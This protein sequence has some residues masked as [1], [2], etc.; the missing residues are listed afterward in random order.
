MPRL[1]TTRKAIVGLG[2]A[3]GQDA[4]DPPHPLGHVQAH[5]PPR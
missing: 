3:A 2:G 1:R 4:T 5:P